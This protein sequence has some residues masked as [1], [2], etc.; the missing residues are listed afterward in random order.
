MSR[1]Q[2]SP[3]WFYTTI[4]IPGLL[5][6]F[7]LPSK[8]NQLYK[9]WIVKRYDSELAELLQVGINGIAVIGG[10]EF[11]REAFHISRYHISLR[12]LDAS[13]VRLLTL[14][15]ILLPINSGKIEVDIFPPIS[16]P[17]GEII[18][19]VINQQFKLIIDNIGG[20]N[21]KAYSD[22]ISEPLYA[23]KVG[24]TAVIE[25][26]RYVLSIDP[27]CALAYK[28]LLESL[29]NDRGLELGIQQVCRSQIAQLLKKGHG[30]NPFALY[31]IAEINRRNNLFEVAEIQYRHI[32]EASP[33]FAPAYLGLSQLSEREGDLDTCIL[34]FGMASKTQNWG[35]K[36]LLKNIL[37]PFRNRL[38][39]KFFHGVNDNDCKAS[40][41]RANLES[42]SLYLNLQST[43]AQLVGKKYDALLTKACPPDAPTNEFK[44]DLLF[45]RAQFFCRFPHL[46]K[47][48]KEMDKLLLLMNL[49]KLTN[50]NTAFNRAV[51][52]FL[53][54]S[55][56]SSG[57]EEQYQ[58]ARWWLAHH[59]DNDLSSQIRQ[60]LQALKKPK[61]EDAYNEL[62][63]AQALMDLNPD[64]PRYLNNL[65]VVLARNG[66]I[67]TATLALRQA[68]MLSPVWNGGPPNKTQ[69]YQAIYENLQ[70]CYDGS[71]NDQET[72][73]QKSK[74]RKLSQEAEEMASIFSS[75]IYQ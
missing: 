37:E 15:D 4:L 70:K 66:F 6:S 3:S 65:A 26:I 14:N 9:Q 48:K 56:I 27:Y 57:D 20:D 46:G 64:D 51:F 1:F 52:T 40:L 28:K 59:R 54:A 45:N 18:K 17:Q 12:V 53:M 24:T 75:Y 29:E 49:A 34:Y 47:T 19:L 63:L 5:L 7:A 69:V 71:I 30:P 74:Y 11:Q 60:A 36:R 23:V 13:R 44:L 35:G 25:K 55:A 8:A 32:L 67:M 2:S 10:N 33:F 43:E 31:T 58:Y 21:Y 39:E 62:L 41:Q 68:L 16:K 73:G 22:R 42:A 38:E 72:S 50:Q 61:D